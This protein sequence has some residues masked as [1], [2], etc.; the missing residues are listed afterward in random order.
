MKKIAITGGIGSG[1]STVLL[2]LKNMGYP[3]FSCD[4]I[5]KGLLQDENYVKEV[6]SLFPK[7]VQNGVID[8]SALAQVVF[9]NEENRAKLNSIAHP[10][11]M[12]T[13]FESMQNCGGN[14]SF[15]EVPLLFEGGYANQFDEIII[16]MRSFEKRI[17]S[18]SE[19]DGT[20]K[21]SVLNRMQAQ[22]D[23]ETAVKDKSFH[24]SNIHLLYNNGTK[25]Q[26][27]ADLQ[28]LINTL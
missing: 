4:E 28:L 19:R 18:V 23:Y 9:S 15:A 1:K 14:V 11:I 26:L 16:V 22:L 20:D 12:K 27:Q 13:L 8:K 21:K 10:T 24:Q 6:G 7:V 17:T 5:N 25:G 3:V 2:L